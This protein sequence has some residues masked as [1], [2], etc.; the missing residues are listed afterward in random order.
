MGTLRPGRPPGT[1]LSLRLLPPG[2]SPNSDCPVTVDSDATEHWPAAAWWFT[3]PGP[4]EGGEVQTAAYDSA[5]RARPSSTPTSGAH[6]STR[7]VSDWSNQWAT[8]S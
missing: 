7:R 3:I 8:D 1:C 4:A 2:P 5:R 6:R